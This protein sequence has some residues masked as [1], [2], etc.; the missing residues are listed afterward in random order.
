MV[1]FCKLIFQDD[2]HGNVLGGNKNTGGS[3]WTNVIIPG[4][5]SLSK[6]SLNSGVH[7]NTIYPKD[8]LFLGKRVFQ[9]SE[10]KLHCR[11]PYADI[12]DHKT[13]HN[14]RMYN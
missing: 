12:T 8:L 9:V 5:P 14:V 6:S 4:D 3:D 11:N 10:R 1:F 13:F 7:I 2:V